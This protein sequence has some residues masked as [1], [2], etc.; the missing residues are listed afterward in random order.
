[1]WCCESQPGGVPGALKLLSSNKEMEL[2]LN[3][4]ALVQLAALEG[5]S[6]ASL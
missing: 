1:M 2:L 4:A 3:E 6:I 5:G